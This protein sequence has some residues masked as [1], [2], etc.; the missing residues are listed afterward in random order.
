MINAYVDGE[1]YRF[2]IR[3]LGEWYDL[4]T[5]IGGLNHIM[6]MRG[7][8]IRYVSLEPNCSPC[9]DVFVG[10]R[11]G[12]IHATFEGLIEVVDPFKGLWA[13]PSFNPRLLD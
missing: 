8:R 1:V 9:A 10:P 3:N 6:A 11:D 2:K 7:S 13:E 4:G 5:L 12:L